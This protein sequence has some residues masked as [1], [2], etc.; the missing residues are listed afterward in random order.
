M[1]PLTLMAIGSALGL[2]KSQVVDKPKADKQRKLAAETQRYSP[3]T[4]LQAN[5]VQEADPFGSVLQ[6]GVTGGMLGANMEQAAADK[7]LKMSAAGNK[8]PWKWDM[9]FNLNPNTHGSSY[10]GPYSFGGG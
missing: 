3:W 2:V 6:Y 4:H 8:N 7:A 5:P 1:D 9:N 10:L